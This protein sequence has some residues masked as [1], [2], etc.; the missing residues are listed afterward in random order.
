MNNMC[1]FDVAPLIIVLV[2]W[3]VY[4]KMFT[5]ECWTF[6]TNVVLSILLCDRPVC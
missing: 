6:Y 5:Y 3:H 2:S 4:I 1:A